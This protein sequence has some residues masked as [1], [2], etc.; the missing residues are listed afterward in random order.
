MK[1]LLRQCQ[2]LTLAGTYSPSHRCLKR[3]GLRK[4]GAILLC[5]HHR[6][7]AGRVRG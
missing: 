2:A 6:A 3:S 4:I 5:T 7:L 1:I